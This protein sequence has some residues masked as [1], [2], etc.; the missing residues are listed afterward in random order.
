MD[1]TNKPTLYT[2]G[3]VAKALGVHPRTIKRWAT[4]GKLELIVLPGGK[5][6][7]A[8]PEFDRIIQAKKEDGNHGQALA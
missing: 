4:A 5:F 1:M 2:I 7:I 6:R 3:D 8:E